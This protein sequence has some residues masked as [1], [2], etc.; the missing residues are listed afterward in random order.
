M[1]MRL[2][3]NLTHFTSSGMAEPIHRIVDFPFELN[4]AQ[5]L[6]LRVHRSC[7]SS[8]D[9]FSV[10]S[11]AFFSLNSTEIP[12]NQSNF[13]EISVSRQSFEEAH[14]STAEIV[15]LLNHLDKT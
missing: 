5:A 7:L 14:L 12:M 2:L 13:S 6:S 9:S 1:R 15:D 11:A 3:E 8:N 10:I 4:S